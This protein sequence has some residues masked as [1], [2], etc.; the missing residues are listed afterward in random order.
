MLKKLRMAMSRRDSLYRLFEKL[1]EI[2]DTYID[3]KRSGKRGRGAGGKKL[4]MV[5]VKRRD[6]KSGFIAM[7]AVDSVS[8]ETVKTFLK[9]HL[10][11]GGH[12][13]AHPAL[14]FIKD[15][16]ISMKKSKT[17]RKSGLLTAQGA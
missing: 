1:I 2:D 11:K 4:V 17:S 13:R 15:E 12:V 10:Q 7:E 8:G 3:G 6:K 5:A 9:R 14:N 16:H